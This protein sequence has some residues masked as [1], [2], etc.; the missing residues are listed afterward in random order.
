MNEDSLICKKGDIV[1]F[2]LSSI[3]LLSQISH[4]LSS[5]ATQ[6]E[7]SPFRNSSLPVALLISIHVV[8]NIATFVDHNEAVAPGYVLT[9]TYNPLRSRDSEFKFDG[10]VERFDGK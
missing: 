5:L 7:L 8:P 10:F 1:V 4:Y 9:V 6:K 2:V 3:S